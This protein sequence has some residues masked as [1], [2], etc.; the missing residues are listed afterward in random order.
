MTGLVPC[1]CGP[2]VDEAVVIAD[3]LSA[4]PGFVEPVRGEV[5][6][7]RVGSVPRVLPEWRRRGRGELEERSRGLT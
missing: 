2:K 3:I 1:S 4:I 5:W 6:R 7:N